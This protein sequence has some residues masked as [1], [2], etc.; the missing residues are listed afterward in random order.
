MKGSSEER[1][2]HEES[3][4]GEETV[5]TDGQ[6]FDNQSEAE[7]NTQEAGMMAPNV[8]VRTTTK[9]IPKGII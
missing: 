5:G 6:Q 8:Q 3:N 2:E 7:L 9:M 4:Q 1:E